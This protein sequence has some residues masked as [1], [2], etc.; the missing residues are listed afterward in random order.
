[1]L[2]LKY[3]IITLNKLVIIPRIFLITAAQRSVFVQ[4]IDSDLGCQ[5]KILNDKKQFM[6][7]LELLDNIII[8]TFLQ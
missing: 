5:M 6:K 3:T 4:S 1:M 8:N 7:T 2:L